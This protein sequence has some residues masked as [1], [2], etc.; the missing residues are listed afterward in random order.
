M[1][2]D[3]DSKSLKALTEL[4]RDET[5][6][7]MLGH[8]RRMDLI[9]A[10]R[11]QYKHIDYLDKLGSLFS[12][13]EFEELTGDEYQIHLFFETAVPQMVKTAKELLEKDNPTMQKLKVKIKETENSVWFIQKK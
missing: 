13:V 12:V 3:L 1:F 6:L 2:K 7:R 11:G 9:K 5:R 10:K 8:Q 4:L